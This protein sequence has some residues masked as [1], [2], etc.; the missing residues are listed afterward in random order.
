MSREL[1]GTYSVRDHLRPRAF[2]ADV[3]LFD[4][5]VLPVPPQGSAEEWRRWEREGW[6]PER[7]AEMLEVLGPVA[8]AVPWDADHRERWSE[9]MAEASDVAQR[10]PDQAF[11]TTGEV[12]TAGLPRHV[13]GVEAVG[14]VYASVED[15]ETNL[16][17]SSQTRAPALP[18]GSLANVI[19]REFFFLEDEGA[20]DLELLR[21]AVGLASD[22]WFR[23]RRRHITAWQQDFIDGEGATDRHSIEEACAELRELLEEEKQALRESAFRRVTGYCFRLA[24]AFLTLGLAA[25]GVVDPMIGASGGAFLAVGAVAVDARMNRNP[26]PGAPPPAAF[27]HDVR[28]HFGWEKVA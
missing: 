7:Q 2:V 22:S 13:T 11:K 20:G 23:R 18:G 21:E 1:W 27:V 17:V 15:L 14:A 16:G 5:V 25:G 8:T 4:R 26:L 12:L 6:A 3:M 19:G 28:K 24:P 10:V 9:R